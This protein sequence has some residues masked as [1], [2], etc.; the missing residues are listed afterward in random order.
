MKQKY[1]RIYVVLHIAGLLVL[2]YSGAYILFE[3]H[4]WLASIWVFLAFS[5]LLISLIGYVE[6][7]KR[8]L[9]Y[10]LLSI[11][12]R[13]FS[14]NF[15]YKNKKELNYAFDQINAVLKDLRN[16]KASN[17]L[18]LQ[19]VVEHVSVAVICFDERNKVQLLNRAAKE[20]FQKEHL[21]SINS[22]ATISEEI[23]NIIHST[24]SN[25]KELV[26]VKIGNQFRNL[27]MLVTT[28]KLQEKSFKLV[29]F[30]DIKNE[31]EAQEM[32]SWQRLIRV[33]THEIKNSVIPISTLSEVT[34]QLIKNEEQQYA[35][36]NL[37]A[38][39][40]IIGGLET[41]ESRSKGLAHFVNTYDQLTKMPKPKLIAVDLSKLIHRLI[42]LFKS[43]FETLGIDL[44]LEVA[45]ALQIE[46]DPDLIDQVLINLL[47]NAMDAVKDQTVR[48]I[49]IKAN[50]DGNG[51]NVEVI[52]NGNGIP[53]EILENIF[54]PFYTTKQGGSGIGLSISRQ[55]MKLHNGS[56]TV[57]ST[58]KVGTVFKLQF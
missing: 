3:T 13:D 7:S 49:N 9:A 56:L 19:T 45:E 58:S 32:E 17:Y 40:D 16:E 51:I 46:A 54:V 18:Y 55:I 41:I 20:L 52:D 27:S 6:R 26:K 31:L 53:D 12:Q 1:F 38:Y 15:P 5:L 30:Q 24:Q 47:K 43:D 29:S 44:K 14:N 39:Q 2:G 21:T 48:R 28:F 8:D 50:Y 4:F 42:N 23:T 22:L 25:S 33:L 35:Q 36:H 34:L 57:G 11:K 37:E 10:F